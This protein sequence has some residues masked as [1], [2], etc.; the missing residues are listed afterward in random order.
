MGELPN[1]QTKLETTIMLNNRLFVSSLACALCAFV[2]GCTKS[3]PWLPLG[4]NMY[5]GVKVYSGAGNEKGLVGIVLGGNSNC[6]GVRSVLIQRLN[7]SAEWQD[8]NVISG[9]DLWFV[10]ADDPALKAQ[11]WEVIPCP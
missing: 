1:I 9:S 7:G 3:S 2:P 4:G 11:A 8:R 6:R 10:R 5:K